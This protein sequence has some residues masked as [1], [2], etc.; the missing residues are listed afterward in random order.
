MRRVL[1]A[2]IGNVFLHDDAFGVEV[3]R[4]LGAERLPDGV[5]LY[6]VGIRGLHLAFQLVEGYDLFV[7]VDLVT[8]GGPPGTLY[9]VEPEL[10]GTPVHPDAHSVDLRTVFTMVRALGGRMCRSIVVGCEPEALR[11]GLGLSAA[12]DAAVEPAVRRVR[13][14]AEGAI[15]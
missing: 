7:A 4:R 10:D 11:E 6:D 14:L 1:I 15:T 2:G 9:V 13:Q 5:E 3:V 8:R 12:V